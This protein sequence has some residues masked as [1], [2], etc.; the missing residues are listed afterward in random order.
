MNSLQ[1]PYNP[2]LLL[3]GH[4]AWHDIDEFDIREDND[5]SRSASRFIVDRIT[6]ALIATQYP[7]ILER[8]TAVAAPPPASG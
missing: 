7:A 5:K 1:L 6:V 8:V 2:I 3:S 4:C